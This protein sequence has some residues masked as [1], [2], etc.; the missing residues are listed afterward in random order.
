MTFTILQKVLDDTAMFGYELF[1]HQNRT[2]K[3]RA[4]S[5]QSDYQIA[6]K[7]A[8][9]LGKLILQKKNLEICLKT[10]LRSPAEICSETGHFPL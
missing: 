5:H 10:I 6:E 3:K 8:P 2:I 4:R 9:V 7:L 1:L